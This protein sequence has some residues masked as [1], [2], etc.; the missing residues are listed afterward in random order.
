MVMSDF[1]IT[2]FCPSPFVGPLQAAIV[3]AADISS[4][5]ADFIVRL[6]YLFCFAKVNNN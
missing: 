1:P 6:I 5:V 2:G 3:I 4:K